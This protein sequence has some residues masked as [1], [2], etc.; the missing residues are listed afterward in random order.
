MRHRKTLTALIMLVAAC[1]GD[2]L[3]ETTAPEVTINTEAPPPPPPPTTASPEESPTASEEDTETESTAT[4][5]ETPP[6]ETVQCP[7]GTIPL[8]EGGC[9]HVFE[10]TTVV[11][12]KVVLEDEW[13]RP[14]LG[15][16][17][18]S[19]TDPATSGADKHHRYDNFLAVYGTYTHDA[20]Y[21]FHTD[22]DTADSDS[23]VR[24]EETIFYQILLGGRDLLLDTDWAYFPYRYDLSWEE[25]PATVRLEAAYPL[26]EEVTMLVNYDGQK[27]DI[28]DEI[29]VPPAPP[30][31]PTTPFAESR[32]PDTATDLGRDCP[33]VEEL[34]E[35][36]KTVEDLCT[37][38]AIQTAL[39]WAWSAPSDLRQ[40]AIRDGHVLTEFFH[41]LDNI[42]NPILRVYGTE[43]GRAGITVE[44]KDERWV[45]GWPGSSMIKL[46]YRAVYPD[47]TLTPELRDALVAHQRE[48]ADQG[49][50][51]PQEWLEGNFSTEG[52]A[53]P[54]D[55]ALMVRTADGTWRMSYRSFCRKLAITINLLVDYACPEDPTPHFPDSDLFDKGIQP[56]NTL[57]YYLDPRD[58]AQGASDVEGFRYDNMP[59]R[60][61]EG[62]LG[63]PPS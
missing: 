15:E 2:T 35:Q 23:R 52:G 60:T 21:F 42:E 31:R 37:L 20:F 8:D 6:A 38:E 34:W 44:F 58:T 48:L 32:W 28:P 9:L 41:Q 45:G 13:W 26:G 22:R 57:L 14:G 46:E 4:E 54:W 25:Y 27:W 62:Y 59:S 5:T 18:V 11:A 49:F 24:Q 43:E 19:L 33:P 39:N 3:T 10:E 30:I 53:D 56:P 47:W 17:A 55:N 50:D 1:G 63:V 29:E 12:P 16:E 51:I 61:I 40:R 36:G 7:E